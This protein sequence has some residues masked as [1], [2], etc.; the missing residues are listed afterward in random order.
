MHGALEQFAAFPQES[1]DN[2]QF[3]ASGGKLKIPVLAIGGAKSYG[4]SLA[5]EIGFAASNVTSASVENSG[6]WLIEEQP[7]A[8]I[9]LI[10]GFL[11]P[12]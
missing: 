2:Q 7:E 3:V 9:T 5:A 6:H 1:I 4:A 10:T 12:P 11:A 8:T